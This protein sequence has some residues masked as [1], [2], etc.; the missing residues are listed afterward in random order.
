MLMGL[1]GFA[2]IGALLPTSL[3][4]LLRHCPPGG[5][6][7]SA[8]V[9]ATSLRS[10]PPPPSGPVQSDRVTSVSCP[11]GAST[12][13]L[14]SAQ[15]TSGQLAAIKVRAARAGAVCLQVGSFIYSLT[16]LI[17]ERLSISVHGLSISCVL[18]LVLGLG[19]ERDTSPYPHGAEILMEGLDNRNVSRQLLGFSCG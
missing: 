8:S 12:C 7:V 15:G 1:R 5:T 11:R 18:G 6:L 9:T 19:D 10:H 4:V 14:R 13:S 17:S 16:Y 3:C 2:H